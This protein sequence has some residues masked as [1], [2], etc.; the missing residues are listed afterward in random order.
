[1]IKLLNN[2]SEIS[3]PD[4]KVDEMIQKGW[5]IFEDSGLSEP[6]EIIEEDSEEE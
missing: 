2:G 3:V 4:Y 6:D 1:M 5:V